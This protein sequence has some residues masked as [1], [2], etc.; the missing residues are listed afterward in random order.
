[1]F[2]PF[3]IGTGAQLTAYVFKAWNLY[4]TIPKKGRKRALYYFVEQST[5]LGI[6]SK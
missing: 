5:H 3:A 6:I 1:M 4:F 2:M